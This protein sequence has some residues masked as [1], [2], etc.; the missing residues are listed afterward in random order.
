MEK[1]WKLWVRD[2]EIRDELLRITEPV[3][4][5]LEAGAIADRLVKNKSKAVLFEKTKSCLMV[6]SVHSHSQ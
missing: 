6:A 2:L 3:A 5:E 1:P 4:V